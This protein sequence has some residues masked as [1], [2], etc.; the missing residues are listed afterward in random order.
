M[1]SDKNYHLMIKDGNPICK[2]LDLKPGEYL[3]QWQPI[4]DLQGNFIIRKDRS[5]G[6]KTVITLT[7]DELKCLLIMCLKNDP[8]KF[9][10]QDQKFIEKIKRDQ[11]FSKGKQEK[12]T[13]S[14]HIIPLDVCIRSKLVVEA[15]KYGFFDANDPEENRIDL[16]IECHP[17]NH[18]KYSKEVENILDRQWWYIVKAGEE[19]NPQEIKETLTAI[20]DSIKQELIS[21]RDSRRS[22]EEF[23][24]F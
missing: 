9:T 15:R 13:V 19:N 5:N 1:F 2:Y 14:H 3:G 7:L 23:Y 17:S 21:F 4:N 18:P 24:T 22:I 8:D 6:R 12:A 16:P 20:V 11:N 10:V